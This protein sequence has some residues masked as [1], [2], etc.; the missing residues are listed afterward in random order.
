MGH[1]GHTPVRSYHSKLRIIV[2]TLSTVVVTLLSVLVYVLSSGRPDS[3]QASNSNTAWA[4][5]PTQTEILVSRARIEQGMQIDGSY[6]TTLAVPI[7]EIPEGSVLA[8]RSGEIV[9]SY[10]KQ[11]VPAGAFIQS[12]L[13]SREVPV[14]SDTIPP[15]MRAVTI[16]LDARAGVAGH[17]RPFSRVDVLCTYEQKGMK[18]IGVVV[19][20]AKVFSV[21]GDTSLNNQSS[22]S[23]KDASSVTLVVKE[24]DAL[25]IELART[26]GAL[27]LNLVGNTTEIPSYKQAFSLTQ[28]NLFNNSP[29]PIMEVKKLG[30]MTM[31][32]PRDQKLVTF[33]LTEKGWQEEQESDS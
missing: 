23:A 9:G 5:V 10:A 22:N 29:E 8:T 25:K 3:V 18:E 19:P 20:Y 13:F 33:Y 16:N 21:N 2:G 32:R 24:E 28:K 30:T 26:V 7:G 14:S 6:L 12:E 17:V 4:A 15:G 31:R 1:F 27:S 11:L